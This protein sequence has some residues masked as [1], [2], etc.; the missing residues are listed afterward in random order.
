LL[1]VIRNPPAEVEIAIAAQT[2]ELAAR[3]DRYRQDRANA[4]TNE[5]LQSAATQLRNQG[6]AAYRH[7]RCWIT[8]IRA[9]WTSGI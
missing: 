4:P 1:A 3:L 9:H 5:E 7:E 6:D 8:C 2:G